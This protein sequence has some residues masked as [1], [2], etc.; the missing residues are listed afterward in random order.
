[1]ENYII[2]V[3]TIQ[4]N[5]KI[6]ISYILYY[7]MSLDNLQIDSLAKKMNVPLEWI[8]YKDELL[9]E[10]IH[11]NKTYIINLEDENDKGNGS[12]WVGLQVQHNKKSN[13]IMPLY[14]D[15]MGQPP[16]E[17]IKDIIKKQFNKY[18][19]YS[20]KNIQS[21]M[22]FTCGFYVL[23]WA[24]YI[25]VFKYRTGNI[26]K[27]SEI[28][29][30]LFDDLNHY[31]DYKKNEYMLRLFFQHPNKDNR[32]PINIDDPINTEILDGLNIIES[33]ITK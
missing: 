26:Y 8:G 25:N 11:T 14:F 3:V 13:E 20:T 10:K 4:V 7:I 33:S 21:I 17:V 30:S 27:D 6:N 32:K 28:F 1:M 12:H 18:L 29:L 22:A 19:A 16:P 5:Y 9:L 31:N 23:A 2:Q 15:S 24:H